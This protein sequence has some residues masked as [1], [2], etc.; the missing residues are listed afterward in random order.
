[1]NQR[2]KAD[3]KVPAKA[4]ST[5]R[6]P[7]KPSAN[8]PSPVRPGPR[9]GRGLW[10]ERRGPSDVAATETAF[11]AR[12]AKQEQAG[13]GDEQ[14]RHEP[15]GDSRRSGNDFVEDLTGA[16][17]HVEQFCDQRGGGRGGRGAGRGGRHR[18]HCDSWET[19]ARWNRR[20]SARSRRK[21]TRYLDPERPGA[22]ERKPVVEE[23]QPGV[24]VCEALQAVGGE[25]NACPFAEASAKQPRGPHGR[26]E[27]QEGKRDH[28]Q[29]PDGTGRLRVAGRPPGSGQ[30]IVEIPNGVEGEGDG[31]ISED[32][33]QEYRPVKPGIDEQGDEANSL[34]EQDAGRRARPPPPGPGT[35]ATSGSV[36]KSSRWRPSRRKSKGKMRWRNGA[37]IAIQKASPRWKANRPIV[38]SGD[39]SW[40]GEAARSSA[41]MCRSRA[42]RLPA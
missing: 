18:D 8:R 29:S 2:R 1:M 23:F 41:W 15:V 17:E 39:A 28:H 35:G 12:G 13:Q 36:R 31:R 24:G 33:Q 40:P 34:A 14:R 38:T 19:S 30:E 27:N 25:H 37:R 32:Q 42:T 5:S 3:Q 10:I 4:P 21:S 11:V 20:A 22:S 26:N 7:L 6:Q 16:G 9:R